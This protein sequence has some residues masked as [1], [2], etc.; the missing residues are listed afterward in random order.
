MKQVPQG[1]IKMPPSALS[2]EH[3]SRKRGGAGGG[4]LA[5][6]QP[7]V[8]VSVHNVPSPSGPEGGERRG[9]S[10]LR[11]RGTPLKMLLLLTKSGGGEALHRGRAW[12]RLG[13]VGRV[14]EKLQKEGAPRQERRDG[15]PRSHEA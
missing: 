10:P 8:R 5:R 7:R 13:G 14:G 3:G 12:V 11:S 2:R 15:T 9:Q 1:D 4:V 6:L